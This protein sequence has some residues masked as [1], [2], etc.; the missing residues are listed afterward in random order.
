MLIRKASKDTIW[1]RLGTHLDG[2]NDLKLFVENIHYLKSPV[3]LITTDG[4]TSVPDKL[5]PDIVKTVLNSEMIIN[6][7]TQNLS[8]IETKIKPYPIGFNLHTRYHPYIDSHT[9]WETLVKIRENAELHKR[10]K[11]IYCDFY[12][13]M[14]ERHDQARQNAYKILKKT[15][16]TIFPKERLLRYDL[17]EQYAKSQFV[18]SP[19]GEGL[20]CYRT[21]EALALGAIPIVKSST[22]DQLYIDLP[23]VIVESWKE[24]LSSK[25]LINWW[26]KYSPH[27]SSVME[28]LETNYWFPGTKYSNH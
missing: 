22:L 28:K 6:W 19:H 18:A 25:N 24:C 23:V 16:S 4:D 26:N 13:S 21:W 1:I 17:W 3:T 14:Y 2:E 5:P 7:Y 12:L 27:L 20:D 10:E 9:T 8:S 15:K 11:Q